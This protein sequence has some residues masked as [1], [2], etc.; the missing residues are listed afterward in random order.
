MRTIKLTLAYDGSEFFGW[1]I[2]PNRPTVQAAVMEAV[3][4]VTGERAAVHGSGRTDAGVHALAQVASF[5]TAS[6]IPAAKLARALNRQLPSAIRV[7]AAEE[8]PPGFHARHQARAKTY[9]YRIYRGEI[10]PPFLWRYVHH[11]PYPLDEQQMMEAA[12]LFEG[13]HDFTSLASAE[14]PAPA[15]EARE[16][17]PHEQQRPSKSQVRTV[18]SSELRREGEEL[19]YTVRGSGF[20]HHMV[21][22]MAGTLVEIGKGRLSAAQIPEILT[23][24]RRSAAGPTLPGKG[25]WLLSVEY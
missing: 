3:A 16:S 15:R 10:C 23:A 22:N 5:H 11:F 19:L 9:R 2:Q 6:G 14:A 20:L 12:P 17:A 1:Q 21:R 24:R 7:L 4:A 8:A 13:A 25:L 18:F